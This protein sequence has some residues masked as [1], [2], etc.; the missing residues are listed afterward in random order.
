MYSTGTP[1]FLAAATISSDST[2]STRGSFAPC[3]TM[4]GTLILSALNSGEMLRSRALSVFGSP[5]SA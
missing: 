1:F 5:I 4:S 3:S 2:L